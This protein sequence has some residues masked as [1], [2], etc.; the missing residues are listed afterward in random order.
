MSTQAFSAPINSLSLLLVQTQAERWK[1]AAAE[2][3]TGVHLYL[4]I[5]TSGYL[6]HDSSGIT[7]CYYVLRASK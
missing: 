6:F 4:D 7:M 5:A 2:Q 1:A 3:L